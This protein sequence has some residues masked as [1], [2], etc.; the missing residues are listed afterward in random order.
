MEFYSVRS[1]AGAV[2]FITQKTF[3]VGILI[4]HKMLVKSRLSLSGNYM[5]LVPNYT[6]RGL[7]HAVLRGTNG[8]VSLQ[9]R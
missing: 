8:R 5:F 6:F 7:I 3:Q 1:T 2:I 9:N 4:E